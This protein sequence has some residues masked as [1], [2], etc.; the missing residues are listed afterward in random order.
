MQT[1]LYT[2]KAKQH[3][4]YYCLL[5]LGQCWS[6][7]PLVMIE[8]MVG[9]GGDGGGNLVDLIALIADLKRL[10]VSLCLIHVITF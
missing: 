3:R 2:S 7:P 1:A 9:S 5:C 6:D 10:K 8:I 4:H